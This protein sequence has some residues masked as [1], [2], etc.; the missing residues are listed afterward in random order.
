MKR[1]RLFLEET[2]P[3]CR[4]SGVVVHPNWAWVHELERELGRLL[5]LEEAAQRLGLPGPEALPPEEEPCGECG[6]EGRLRRE[7]PLEEALAE[8]GVLRPA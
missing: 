8:L 4:G 3:R 2:C 5:S 1:Y 6:G 7:V